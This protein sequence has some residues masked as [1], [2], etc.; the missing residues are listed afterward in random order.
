M[1]YKSTLELSVENCSYFIQIATAMTSTDV[2]KQVQ[3]AAMFDRIHPFTP[4]SFQLLL[5]QYNQSNKTFPLPKNRFNP[6]V[7]APTPRLVCTSHCLFESLVQS[8]QL[9]EHSCGLA[10]WQ[11][12]SWCVFHEALVPGAPLFLPHLPYCT[13]RCGRHSLRWKQARST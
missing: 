12:H 10:D 3:T 11:V 1:Q 7:M 8:T 5:Q 6:P 2:C 9:L 4:R 13:T